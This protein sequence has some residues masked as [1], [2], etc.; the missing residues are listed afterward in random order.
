[1][2]TDSHGAVFRGLWHKRMVNAWHH[3]WA[4]GLVETV[5]YHDAGFYT[6]PSQSQED[7]WYVV[8]R[9]PLAPDGYLW[10]CSCRASEA[11]GFV[12][13]HGFAAYLW[14][15]RHVMRWRLKRP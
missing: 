15:L 11:G 7:K 9:F 1:M 6:V 2:P 10:V 5:Q 12:C 8:Y 3:A 14:R 13:A 4:S